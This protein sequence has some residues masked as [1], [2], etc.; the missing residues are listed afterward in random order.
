MIQAYSMILWAKANREDFKVTVDKAYNVLIT[1]KEYGPELS[2]NYLPAYR[3]KDVKP[4]D[5]NYSNL[6]QLIKKN[7]NREGN[8]VFEDLGH[9]IGFFS[10][11]KDDD[12]AGIHFSIGISNPQ[13]TNSLV[14]DF[15]LSMDIFNDSISESLLSLFKKC[16]LI[17]DPFWGCIKSSF[18]LNK[19]GTIR[20]NEKPTTIHWVN[21][22]D[23]DLAR[24]VTE[25]RIESASLYL[26]EKTENGGYL[27][28]LQKKPDDYNSEEDMKLQDKVNKE[29][30]L[31]E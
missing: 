31:V 23:K 12:S 13:F 6:E 2:P 17:F 9:T 24:K 11:L 7:V 27:L 10:S 4:Y 21:Y 8:L 18:S 28:V 25:Q 1:L 20:K 22:W 19:F 5:L 30:G 3:K 15:P 14:V 26:K 29:L 16:V